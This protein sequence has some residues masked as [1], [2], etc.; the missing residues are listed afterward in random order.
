MLIEELLHRPPSVQHHAEQKSLENTATALWKELKILM[1]QF[2][3][4]VDNYLLSSKWVDQRKNRTYG[5]TEPM[6]PQEP[7]H[8]IRCFICIWNDD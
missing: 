2:L 6:Y 5:K 3:M 7:F 8:Y 1:K 4:G